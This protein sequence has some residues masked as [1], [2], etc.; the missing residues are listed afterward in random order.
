MPY[1]F[2]SSTGIQL[3]SD[4]E[5]CV[6]VGVTL[7]LTCIASNTQSMLWR[8]TEYIGSSGMLRFRFTNEPG[9]TVLSDKVPTTL[10]TFVNAS[11]PFGVVYNL[12]SELQIE[13]LANYTQFTVSCINPGGAS[14]KNI[15]F[16]LE[17]KKLNEHHYVC[18]WISTLLNVLSYP[19]YSL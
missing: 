11:G 8:S 6:M 19:V 4:G 18:F 10:A 2:A 17:G 7:R 9:D 16:Y 12:E 1:A 13:V 15:T 14:Q 3:T 5:K